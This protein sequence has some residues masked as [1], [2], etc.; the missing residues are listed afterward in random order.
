MQRALIGG[1]T[2]RGGAVMSAAAAAEA[3]ELWM[4]CSAVWDP[5]RVQNTTAYRYYPADS[6]GSF[7]RRLISPESRRGSELPSFF[8][9]V[10]HKVLPFFVTLFEPLSAKVGVLE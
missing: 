8:Q 6:L 7:Q 5:S 10:F 9:T 2:R 4:R 3:L 1:T